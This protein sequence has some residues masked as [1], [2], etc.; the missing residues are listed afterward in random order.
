[1]DRNTVIKG[2]INIEK[3]ASS[4]YDKLMQ[5]FPDKKEFWKNLFDDELEHVSFLNDVT[6]LGLIDEIE[7]IDFLPSMSVINKTLKL[8]D[9]ITEQITTS[10]ISLEDALKLMLKLEK[11]LVETYTN[12]LIARLI[13]CDEGGGE[14]LIIDE[15]THIDKI[16]EMMKVI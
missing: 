9:K 11:S 13:S 14:K 1:M 16:Q 10:S 7:K 15:K 6:S 3:S 5:I 12:K 8:A 2:C 4:L